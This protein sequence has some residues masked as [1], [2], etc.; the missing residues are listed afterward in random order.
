MREQGIA[1]NTSPS[2]ARG[3]SKTKTPSAIYRSRERGASH[4]V[5]TRD[6][7]ITEQ[8]SL[9]G[10]YED[11][12]RRRLLETRTAVVRAWRNV[13]DTLDLHGEVVFAGEVRSFVRHL[14]SVQTDN[15]S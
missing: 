2:V 3:R 10:I 6:T 4:V 5:R 15:E 11:P 1:A 13:A 14:A 9:T 7:E 8:F 12:S